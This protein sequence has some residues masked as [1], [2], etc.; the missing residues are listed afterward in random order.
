M[1]DVAERAGV[2]TMTVSRALRKGGPISDET[3][4]RI[5]AA[6]DE[7]GYV[8]DQTA[9][10]LSSKRSGFVATLIPSI[11]NSNFSDTVRGI[12]EAI[13][14]SGLQLLLGR[15]DYL[16][17]NEETLLESMLTRRPEGIILTGGSHT[18]R[19]RRLLETVGI[20]V[21]E[22]WD[23]PLEP[24]EHVIGFSNAAAIRALAHDLH[25]RGYRNI[26][27]IGG[28]T[29]RDTRGADRRLGY[30]Q[31][32]AELGLGQARIISFGSPP[33][34]MEQGG[35]AIAQL[36]DQ[37]PEVDAAI[38][39]SDLSAFGALM[40]CH[41]RGISVPGRIAIAGF[42]DFEVSRCS[43]PRLT[44]VSVDA[45]EIGR[46]AGS[47]LLRAIEARRVGQILPPERHEMPFRV[48]QRE[49]T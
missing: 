44:T 19:S 41:R 18:P 3:R 43:H 31:A 16:V 22:T 23:L 12:G 14:G 2:S 36:L 35:E 39:V 47:L 4:R 27:F 17:E 32:I 33:I 49:S 42:G 26:G 48:V 38:C 30:S 37:W 20:P 40:E 46:A 24:I 5:M 28:T 15:T 11:N 1:A 34:S 10:T 13:E 7:L 45:V 25:A 6:I 29:N 8:L 21:V 9:G